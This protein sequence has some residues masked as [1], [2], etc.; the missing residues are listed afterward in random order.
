MYVP[1]AVVGVARSVLPVTFSG[2]VLL[3]TAAA[4][5]DLAGLGL[6]AVVTT[7]ALAVRC[8]VSEGLACRVLTGSRPSSAG[9]AAILAGATTLACR[10]GMGP[11]VVQMR[12]QPGNPDLVPYAWGTGVVVVP[13]GLVL[14][15]REGRAGPAEAA[16]GLC[17]AGA[18]CRAGL[19]SSTA[20]LALWCLPWSVAAGFLEGLGRG[21]KASPLVWLAWRCR[22]V[23]A[24]IAVVQLSNEGHH[25]M[26]AVVAGI[27]AATYAQPALGRWFAR[28]VATTGDREVVGLGLGVQFARLLA[29]AG[30]A[31]NLERHDALAAAQEPQSHITLSAAGTWRRE[32]TVPAG[33]PQAANTSRRSLV[34]RAAHLPGA[35]LTD[36][37]PG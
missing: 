25:A 26:G 22:L 24:S 36:V 2:L 14:A 13:G 18:T 15:L 20:S 23:V 29:A 21:V 6:F 1:T 17:H 4:L 35:P 30:H 11:P 5:P 9:E 28:R 31:I 3:L 19:G 37:G 16:A 8:G 10:A 33:T 34:P 7:S 12:V 27:G 32:L